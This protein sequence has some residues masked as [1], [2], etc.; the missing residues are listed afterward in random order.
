MKLIDFAVL[1]VVAVIVV[2]VALYI[3]RA[4]KKGV[5]CI[6]CSHSAACSGGCSGSCAS[7]P[8]CRRGDS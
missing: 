6:G 4:K 2:S 5:R 1:F 8:G 3:Y 7:C